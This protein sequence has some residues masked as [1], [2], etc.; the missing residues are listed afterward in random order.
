MCQDYSSNIR[1]QCSLGPRNNTVTIATMKYYIV[2]LLLATLSSPAL[3]ELSLAEKGR[4]FL[5]KNQQVEGVAITKSGLQ[6][7][8]LEPGNSK[9]PTNRSQVTINYQGKHVDNSVFDSTF[10]DEPSVLSLRKAIKG[11]KEGLQ[12]IGE[13]GR[14]V[15]FV[16]SR[17]AYG[18]DGAP[19]IIKRNETL[20]FIID[21]LEVHD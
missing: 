12:F 3:A 11:W 14:I 13:G 5:E 19:P 15:L 8:I 10:N 6:Y 17:L 2:L 7:K 21:L 9:R 1:I 18:R 4:A 20:I 16:P